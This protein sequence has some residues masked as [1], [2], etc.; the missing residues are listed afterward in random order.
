MPS[1]DG[2]K[3]CKTLPCAPARCLR[4]T[5]TIFKDDA[6]ALLFLPEHVRECPRSAPSLQK[7]TVREASFPEPQRPYFPLT[8]TSRSSETHGRRKDSSNVA[9][10]PARRGRDL[11]I[12]KILLA[13]LALSAVRQRRKTRFD[14]IIQTTA[15][16]HPGPIYRQRHRSHTLS[17][18][19]KCGASPLLGDT[20]HHAE[21]GLGWKEELPHCQGTHPFLKNTQPPL[22][23]L[24]P[25]GF[26]CC[27]RK[28]PAP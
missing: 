9:V 16:R 23:F 28:G 19:C 21:H 10:F 1:T 27:I 12:W 7:H 4:T 13:Y 5:P 11:K 26:P 6:K 20:S 22:E 14:R 25:A 3:F 2:R 18:V 17:T 8:G 15:R 24:S